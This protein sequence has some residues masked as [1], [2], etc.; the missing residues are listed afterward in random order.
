MIFWTTSCALKAFNVPISL[1]SGKFGVYSILLL[2]HVIFLRHGWWLIFFLRPKYSKAPKNKQQ[3]CFDSQSIVNLSNL[4]LDYSIWGAMVSGSHQLFSRLNKLQ[5]F[6]L[7]I[8][9]IC[10]NTLKKRSKN[11]HKTYTTVCHSNVR[12]NGCGFC[13][14][15][16]SL[17][18]FQWRAQSG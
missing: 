16:S 13:E 10:K 2:H 15:N 3:R 8:F 12:L 11:T 5:I 18:I 1:R 17:L 7:A 9:S 4:T 6:T 14:L